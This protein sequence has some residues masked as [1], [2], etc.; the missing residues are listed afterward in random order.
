MDATADG[1][2]LCLPYDKLHDVLRRLPPRAIPR[3]R[4][5][6]RAWRTIIDAHRLLPRFFTSRVFPCVFTNHFGC[7]DE[8]YFLAPPVSRSSGAD[9]SEFQRPLFWHSWARV[10]EHCN[11][12]LLLYDETEADIMCATLRQY[13][14]LP[15]LAH[16]TYGHTAE[17]RVYQVYMVSRIEQMYSINALVSEEPGAMIVHSMVF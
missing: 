12:L 6:R 8:S 3:S 2:G 16:R 4:T 13:G 5:V 15:C 7:R 14:A 1:S 17:L 11:G 9:K 10:T